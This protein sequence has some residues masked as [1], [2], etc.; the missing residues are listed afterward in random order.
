MMLTNKEFH[1]TINDK[2]GAFILFSAVWCQPCKALTRVIASNGLHLQGPFYKIDIDT[3]RDIANE[4]K[5]KAVPTIIYF[6]DGKEVKRAVGNLNLTK[7]QDL[8]E[9]VKND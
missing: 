6:A 3:H 9:S 7:L 1:E 5:I 4:Y 8:M 2:E